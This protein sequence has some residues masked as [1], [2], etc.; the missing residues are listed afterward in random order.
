MFVEEFGVVFLEFLEQ[1]VVFL[2]DVHAFAR[3]HEEEYGVTF[4]MA[5][6]PQTE[7]FA[8]RGAFDDAWDVGD[9]EGL[10]VVVLHYAEVGCQSGE[11][12]VGDFG[13]S[14]G[15]DRKESGF[16][17]IGETDE[18]DIGEDFEFDYDPTFFG[19]FARLG[20]ARRLV[21]GGF[22]MVVA[23]TAPSA[24][25]DNGGLVVF[26]DFAQL[27]ARF[28]VAAYASQRDVENLV[29]AFASGAEVLSAVLSVFGEYMFGILEVEEGPAVA[30]AT[31]D[32]VAAA[33]A[34]AAVGS[35]LSVVFD[36]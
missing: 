31:E 24:A 28:G 10:V 15:H 30:V 22:E 12:V 3:D 16:S 18:T 36:P 25:S 32:D 26:G 1:D 8:L 21:G 2:A 4:D 14:C 6:E 34:V 13:F 19:R 29:G 9:A 17:G 33:S 20:V 23:P 35:G 5:Q 27:F 7:T 11:G